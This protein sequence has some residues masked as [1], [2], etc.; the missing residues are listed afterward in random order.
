MKRQIILLVV[1]SILL[2]VPV[3]AET[4]RWVDFNVP[5]ES[6]KYAM[7]VDITT[8]DQE[9]HISWIDILAVSAC[10][11]GGKCDLASVKKVANE[12]KTKDCSPEELTG[13]LSKY[14]SYYHDAY[15]AV[16]SGL[17]G[18]YEVTIN[19]ESKERMPIRHPPYRFH[20]IASITP[21]STAMI[22]VP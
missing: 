5:Y 2:S 7:N 12:L 8:F 9:K 15:S 20:P 18:S 3:S 11:T 17:L 10:R 1:I 22:G 14:Y 13:D 6:L 4:I 16:L 19:G 21:P